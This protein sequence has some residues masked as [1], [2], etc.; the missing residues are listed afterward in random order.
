MGKGFVELKMIKLIKK[1]FTKTDDDFFGSKIFAVGVF[2][3]ELY[4]LGHGVGA[5]AWNLLK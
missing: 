2:W 4:T 1:T 3:L 5:L